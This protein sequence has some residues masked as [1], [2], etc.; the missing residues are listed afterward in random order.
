MCCLVLLNGFKVILKLASLSGIGKQWGMSRPYTILHFCEHFGGAEA[1]LHGVARAFQ[2]WVPLYDAQKFRVLLCSRKGPDK[3]HEEMVASGVTPLTLGYGKHDP[4]NFISLMRLMRREK[5]D[6]VHAHGFGAC[7]WA[8]LAGHLTGTPVIVHGRCNYGTVP[9]IQRPV[10][11]LLGPFTRYALAVSESTRQFTIEKRHIPADRVSVLY[12][13]ILLERVP[14]ATPAWIAAERERLGAGGD[15]IIGVLGRLESYKGHLDA[16]AAMQQLGELPVQLWVIGD[17]SEMAALQAWVTR[18][19][20]SDRIRL[21]GYRRD[22]IELIQ[23]LDIQLFPSHQEGTPNTLFEALAVGN[24]IVASTCDGQGEI[25]EDGVTAGLFAPGDVDGMVEKLRA[26][27]ADAD[28]RR[29]RAAAAKQKSLDF[30]GHKTVQRM[31]AL[32]LQILEPGA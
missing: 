20:M 7:M 15:V 19:G 27:V 9:R 11:R 18:E 31:E 8:R 21:L 16:F 22:A 2:W 10:E 12:N 25:L 24:A 14:V 5:V 3:A 26:L 32:Y 28:L 29:E 4:R 13:G 1:S 30:D 17:G 23:C 6:L